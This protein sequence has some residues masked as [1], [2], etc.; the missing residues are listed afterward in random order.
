M[1]ELSTR[2][3]L[4][5]EAPRIV[6]IRET[7][8]GSLVPSSYTLKLDGTIVERKTKQELQSVIGEKAVD[9]GKKLLTV[10]PSGG[11][12]RVSNT[13]LVLGYEEERWVVIGAVCASDW[14]T[15]SDPQ[16]T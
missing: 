7:Y 6:P 16:E 12:L 15:T 10:H 3:S 8:E 13:G 4:P 9:I 2:K 14:F 1:S 5:N 11:R